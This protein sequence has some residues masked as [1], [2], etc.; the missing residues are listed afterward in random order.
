M[1]CNGLIVT[2][3]KVNR[4]SGRK[5][6]ICTACIDLVLYGSYCSN[7]ENEMNVKPSRI[8]SIIVFLFIVI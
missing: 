4:D 1:H 3:F 7:S 8:K 5:P 6:V 2:L